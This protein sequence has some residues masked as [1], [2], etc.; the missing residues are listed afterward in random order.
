VSVFD[1]VR[2][3]R[4]FEPHSYRDLARSLE[5]LGHFGLAALYHEVLL[6]GRWHGRFGPMKGVVAE[7]YVRMMRAALRE[8]RVRGAL[9]AHFARRLQDLADEHGSASAP[10]VV[11]ATWN[12]DNTDVDLW[13]K[14]PSGE[15]CGYSNRATQRGGELMA[16]LRVGYGP[17]RYVN[18]RGDPGTYVILVNYYRANP[19]LIAGETHVD[20]VVTCHAGTPREKVRRFP[21]VLRREGT[22][23]EVCRIELEA[24]L[25]AS[26]LG[27]G[28]VS[29]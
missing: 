10:L 16:D 3:Q 6:A 19:N 23:T 5:S 22:T 7:E 14:E 28:A 20:V 12:T 13:V 29:R 25:P 8:D 18:R 17:E 26:R 27:R 11:T 24:P 1:R 9:R 4:P 2:E 21:V 15:A